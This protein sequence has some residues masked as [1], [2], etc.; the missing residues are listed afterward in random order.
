M[1]RL[2]G[3]K[4]TNKARMADQDKPRPVSGEMMTDPPAGAT[5]GPKRP[6]ADDVFD[7]D[8]VVLPKDGTAPRGGTPGPATPIASRPAAPEGMDMLRRKA[9]GTPAR[10]SRGGPIFWAAGV[11]LALAVFWI[12]GGHA[13]VRQA[14]FLA[15]SGID[16]R[17]ARSLLS[18]NGVTSRVDSNGARPVLL[19]DGEAANEGESAIPLPP[20]ALN[21]T[22]N[23]GSVTTYRL[24]T[25]GRAL[26]PGERFAFSSRLE[27]PRNGVTAVSVTFAE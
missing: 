11:G 27:V 8:F 15:D 19:V 3:H 20:L 17:A 7:A 6:A 2:P 23:D 9:A 16:G 18:I 24:G 10:S 4:D 5:D 26:S 22:G 21:V 13:L 14:P 25:S 1:E 12:S